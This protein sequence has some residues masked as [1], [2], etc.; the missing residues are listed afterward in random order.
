M[1]VCVV[2]SCAGSSRS[3]AIGSAIFAV[4]CLA[5]SLLAPFAP[6][7]H[8]RLSP[9]GRSCGVGRRA[10]T[11]ACGARGPPSY[12]PRRGPWSRRARCSTWPARGCSPSGARRRERGRKGVR[13][14]RSERRGRREE[15]S[16][17]ALR[18]PR[19]EE[20]SD[21]ALRTPRAEERS[22]VQRR[23]GDLPLHGSLCSPA[24]A[25]SPMSLSRRC[26]FL[27]ASDVLRHHEHLLLRASSLALFQRHKGGR[28]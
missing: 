5:A 10:R 6:R 21:E 27:V 14:A 3:K 25:F 28:T 9:P 23:R 11:A 16:D 15:R 4:L 12:S 19:A 20:R 22:D 17:E 18:T 1:F 24:A 7:P 13:G 8:P 26:R 2:R